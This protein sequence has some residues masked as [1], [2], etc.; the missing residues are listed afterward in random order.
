MARSSGRRFWGIPNEFWIGFV[1]MV[2]FFLK[3]VYVSKLGYAAGT[4]NPGTWQESAE[5][6]RS[7]GSL[8]VISYLYTF[9][10]FPGFSPKGLF[11]YADPPLYYVICSLWMELLHRLMGWSV[12]VS[13]YCVLALNVIYVM[14]GECAGIGILQKLGVRGRKLVVALL[15][16]IFFPSHYHMSGSLSGS[17]LCFMLTILALNGVLSWHRSRRKKELKK[18][19][20]ELGLALM[21]SY[22]A[23]MVIPAMI[24]LF[25]YAS[26]D[27]RRNQTPLSIQF[28]NFAL[29]AGIMA[30]IWPLYISIRFGLPLFYVEGAGVKLEGAYASVFTRLAL[31][32]RSLM[33]HLHTTGDVSREYNIWAQTYKTALV[34]LHSINTSLR[35]THLIT[36]FLLYMNVLLSVIAH[37]MLI[38]TLFFANRI[39]RVFRRMLFI[40]YVSM[41]AAY[42]AACFLVPYTGTMDFKMITAVLM[43]PLAG[44]SVCGTGD[45]S[46]NRFEKITTGI[47]NVMI[48][49][50]AFVTAFL[51][52]F[53]Y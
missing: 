31:P 7:G 25:V 5:A 19:S 3:L 33:E 26:K 22:A 12:N 17:A 21:T 42:I 20:V 28:R 11:G 50:M 10:H 15:F 4:L 29:T 51:F 30:M 8:D 37:M 44:M 40:G 41:L 23:V 39:D 34:D 2:G 6:V 52:G 18:S 13:L 24:V 43:F 48:L 45:L 9:H 46:D 53:Y 1:I 47:T 36:V 35:G 14:V 16:L 32:G 38:Y 27:G 49:G